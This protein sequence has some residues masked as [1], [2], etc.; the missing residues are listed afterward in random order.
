MSFVIRT[1]PSTDFVA[2]IET[3]YFGSQLEIL[4]LECWKYQRNNVFVKN[5]Y[6][7]VVELWNVKLQSKI[8]SVNYIEIRNVV[9]NRTLFTLNDE[10]TTTTTAT[11]TISTNP[12]QEKEIC[13][14]EEE[15]D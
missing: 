3:K 15:V 7:S 4:N 13:F 12:N 10:I 8:I 5:L 9:A 11:K 2:I 14:Q 6:F 1:K